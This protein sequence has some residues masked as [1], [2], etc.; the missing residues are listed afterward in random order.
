MNEMFLTKAAKREK[1][2]GLLE[3]RERGFKKRLSR[4]CEVDPRT[5][6]GWCDDDGSWPNEATERKLWE[7]FHRLESGADRTLQE[8]VTLRLSLSTG[9]TMTPTDTETILK[10][11][12]HLMTADP[13]AMG[14][15]AMTLAEVQTAL[16]RIVK[17]LAGIAA[18]EPDPRDAALPLVDLLSKKQ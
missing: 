11:V 18:Q 5:L 6:L 13:M 14:I 9:V 2:R 12:K 17:T 3:N 7:F 1:L 8:G 15:D 10:F 16:R 4:Y